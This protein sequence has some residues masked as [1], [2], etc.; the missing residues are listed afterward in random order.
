MVNDKIVIHGAR[1]H[2]LKD[3]SLSIPKDKLV[4]IT[5]LSGS[6]KSSLAFDTLYAEGRRRYVESLSSYARQFLGQMDKA[7]VD[8]IDGLNPAISI[9]QKTTSHN[10]RSTVGTVTEINDYLRLLW[11]RVGHP[12]CPNDGTLIE[13][14]SV[15][16]MVDRVMDLPERSR[17]QIL[18]PVIRSKRGEHKEVFKRIQR[19]GYVRVIVDGEMHEITDEFELD[20]NKRH[21]IDIVVDRLIVKE[22]IRSRLFDSVEA[23]LRLADGYMYVDVIK[24]ERI[25]FSE[26]YA[27]PICGFT[28]GEMEP[29]LFS[30]NAPFGACPDC[31]GLGMKLSVDEDLVIPDKDKSLGEGALVPWANSKYYTAMLEQACTALK[32]PLD[33]PYKKLTKRQKDLILNGSKGKKIKFH[34][35]GDFGVNDTVQEFEGILNNINRRYHHPMSKFMRDAMGKYMTELTCSTCHGKRLNEKALAVKVN[36]KDI[37]EASD[38]S[39]AKALEF[40]NSVKL[41]EQEEMI[42]KPILKEVR[43]RLTFLINVGLDYLTLS[44]SA[45]TLSG[46]EAQRIRLATQ[47]GSNLS[48]VMYILD[49]PSIGLHQRDNDRLI[50]SLKKMRDLG[51]SLIVVEH[52]DETMKQADYLVDMGPGAGVYGGKVMAAGTPEEVMKNPHSL[53]GEYL[54]GKKIVPVPLERRKGNGKKITVTGAKENNLKDIS[55]DFPLGKLVVVT[56]VSGSGKS[57]L[58]NLILKRALAQKLNNNSAKP[59]KYE[60]I[61]G[62]KNIEKIIDIDQ[63]PIGRTPRSNPATYTSVFDDIRTLFAQTNEAKM[64]GYTKARFSFN[65]KGGRCEACHGDGIIKIEMNFLP[66]VYVPCE[67]CHG[68][69]YNSE[70]LEVTYREK[71][72]SQVLNMTI[73]EACKFFENI[74]KIHRKL[75][76]IVDV[77]LGYVKLGQSA[78]T[79]SGGEAQRMKLAS[80]LQKLSTGNNFYILDEPTTG[81]HTDDIKRLLEVLQRLVDEGNTVLIIEHNLDVIKNAD[82]LIDLGPEGGDGGGQVVATGTPEEVAQVKESYTGQYL[83]P[84]LE[85][86]TEL[87]KQMINNKKEQGES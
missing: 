31:D 20:K 42:A 16:Q 44:R 4:V 33:K 83:K 60:S 52:D 14:Q 55:V 6:G 66:D 30:F 10:P 40:F 26:Y 35:E 61:K 53:T 63:S 11:A 25:N 77:G 13:R 64:R 68:T 41:S 28:V 9:D 71:N 15:D 1:E 73:N 32:I 62:Y 27:C 45:G 12:I 65:V 43:D 17:I 86:D 76:T 87:T 50:S 23:A 75:Q 59:G 80:E 24:G 47:I 8:S 78:T 48:G 38:L 2:N 69:R 84:V 18:A 51:N 54:S 74:P 34:L 21:S 70:T 49:E 19:A 67:V 36:G 5:G 72:I 57:T 3:I 82:W 56:G 37:A 39:I 29:R 22:N 46:G 79:L 85:R 7:D 81:L 58:V